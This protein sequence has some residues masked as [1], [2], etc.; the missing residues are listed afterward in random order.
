MVNKTLFG[1]IPK[2]SRPSNMVKGFLLIPLAMQRHRFPI[3]AARTTLFMILIQI[4]PKSGKIFLQQPI[5]LHKNNEVPM[6]SLN[7]ITRAPP[8]E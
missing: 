5:C 4:G 6:P 2:I 3:K 8:S 7:K 1:F